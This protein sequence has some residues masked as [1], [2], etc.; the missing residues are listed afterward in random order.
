MPDHFEVS[1]LA[2]GNDGRRDFLRLT[3]GSH[4][5]QR[6]R[7]LA[8]TVK[9]AGH[10]QL[11]ASSGNDHDTRGHAG[12]PPVEPII[13]LRKDNVALTLLAATLGLQQL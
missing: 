1:G 12:E 2:A 11:K 5:G 8:C 3:R 10:A 4:V 9:R 6:S 7:I 13:Y